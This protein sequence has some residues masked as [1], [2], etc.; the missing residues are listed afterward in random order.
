ML[1]IE[2]ENNAHNFVLLNPISLPIMNNYQ[3]FNS[4]QS[5]LNIFQGSHRI[6]KS[7]ALHK[8]SDRYFL[9]EP[10]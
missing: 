6:V 8:N 10:I 3:P 9:F 2:P 1:G 5:E 7:Y 4:A